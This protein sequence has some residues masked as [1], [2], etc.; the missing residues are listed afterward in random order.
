MATRRATQPAMHMLLVVVVLLGLS[1]ASGFEIDM[2]MQQKC[3][4]EEVMANAIVVGNYRAFHKDQSA[5]E[6]LVD[7]KI[8]NPAGV[9]LHEKT[10]QSKGD[11][12]F[13]ASGAGEYRACFT[14]RIL[15]DGLNTRIN[16]EF[17]TGVAATDWANIAKKDHLDA[18]TVE[19]L[20]LEDSI[21]EVYADMLTL[22]KREQEMRDES[23]VT[24]SRVAWY[25]I[26]SLMV[27][28][29]CGVWQVWHLHMFFQ[30]RKLI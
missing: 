14:A 7:L 28:I 1:F 23:E 17:K 2:K 9:V 13:T 3:V 4:Y 16:F 30:K 25:A 6:M 5:V 11:F 19:L 12:A 10:L 15:Q 22:Q 21:R 8:E 26:Y 29:G 20:K 18:L 24:N 27:C